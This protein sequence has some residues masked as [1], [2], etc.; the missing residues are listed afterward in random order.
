V[1]GSAGSGVDTGAA[2]APQ[3]ATPASEPISTIQS[4]CRGAM[5]R[6]VEAPFG[7]VLWRSRSHR[8]AP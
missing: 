2:G 8:S 3:A 4:R 1:C 6:T 7:L 5:L